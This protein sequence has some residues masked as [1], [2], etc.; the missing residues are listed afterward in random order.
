MAREIKG[1]VLTDDLTRRLFSTD[2]S[3]YEF[4][5]LGVVRPQD[6]EDCRKTMRFAASEGISLIARG[7]GTSLAGQCVGPGLVIDFSRHMNEI[8]AVSATA[9]EARVQPGVVLAELNTQLQ[10]HGLMFAP[11]PSTANRCTIGGMLGNNAWGAHALRY[12]TTR[13][14]VVGVEAL[15][16]DGNLVSFQPT[17]EAER[18][19]KLR[20]PGREGEIYRT[21]HAI[22]EAHRG[23]VLDRYPSARG[24]PNNAGYALDVI[25]RQQPWVADGTPFNLTPLLCGSEG[26]LALVTEISLRLEPIPRARLLVCPHFHALEEALEAVS[27]ALFAA[28]SAIEI[29]DRHVLA[30]TWNNTEQSRNRFWVEGDPAAVLLVEFSGDDARQAS[31]ACDALLETYRSHGLG[32]AYPVLRAEEA[33]RAW[34]LRRAGLGLLMG[35]TADRKPVT[36]IEDSAVAVSDLPAYLREVQE[37]LRQYGTTC[38]VYGSAGMGVL[39]LRPLL[40]LRLGSERAI[41]AHVMQGV[42]AIVARYRGSFSAKHGDG[43]LRARFLSDTLGG[44]ITQ[45]LVTLKRAFD[46]DNLL[47]PGAVVNPPDLLSHLRAQTESAHKSFTPT[48]FDWGE[49]G[50]ILGAAARCHGAGVCVQKTGAGTMCPSYRA[51]GEELHTTRGRANLFRL[52][53]AGDAA[54]RPLAIEELKMALD[55]CLECKGCRAECPANVDMAR[56]KA[57][58]LQYYQDRHGVSWRTEV[59]A[60]FSALSKAASYAP[61][62][63]NAVLGSAAAKR[64]LGIHKARQLPRLARK[65][66]SSWCKGRPQPLRARS[67]VVLLV[68]PITEYYEPEIGRAAVEVLER[69]GLMV[70]VTPC[71]SSGRME[72]SLGLLRR[73]RKTMLG[74]IRV[75]QRFPELPIIGLEPSEV[76]T[77]RDELLDLLESADIREQARAIAKRIV[78]FE[79]FLAGMDEHGLAFNP[80]PKEIVLHVHC[81]Q[82]ALAGSQPSVDAL[83]LIP[84]AKVALIPSG[85]C[86]MAGLFGYQSQ[87]YDLSLQI[88]ELVLLPSVRRARSETLVIATGSS[89]RQQIRQALE[90]DVLHPVQVFHKY[91]AAS[92][93][94]PPWH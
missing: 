40:D 82:K 69:L 33:D 29:L 68:D 28:P 34:A 38:V 15:L 94:P 92:E 56:M 89:C 87:H 50:G 20:A 5:P 3:P 91:L 48:H 21:L 83:G 78:V 81:H 80:A 25:A 63:S 44:P 41:F 79:E 27:V 51:L 64:L 66:F 19:R 36:G 31:Q 37:L 73:A 32:Y 22:L 6:T 35:M 55:L 76:Y 70:Y 43:R 13:E 24:I 39:H 62:F 67:A 86:G 8:I 53:L 88:A 65:R 26:T 54:D 1:E 71:V 2:A 61:W 93:C 74:A 72:V 60:R 23:T 57:E 59:L 30:L 58:F 77:Y 11:D 90:L 46:P 10:G 9:R 17:A 18:Q 14:H 47:N 16:S 85:C 4:L 7:A 45:Q 52:L 12:R 84:Q 42:A 49:T 75:L